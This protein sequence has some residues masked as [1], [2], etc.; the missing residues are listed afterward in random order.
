MFFKDLISI[1]LGITVAGRVVESAS[2]FAP[3]PPE[4]LPPRLNDNCVNNGDYFVPGFDPKVDTVRRNSSWDIAI[5]NSDG[6][7]DSPWYSVRPED[8]ELCVNDDST[9]AISYGIVSIGKH[10]GHGLMPLTFEYGKKGLT[11]F[12]GEVSPF[13]DSGWKNE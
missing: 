5:F 9:L 8:S 2:K 3:R 1:G 11:L 7:Q 10:G 4:P 6:E 12:R 13:E